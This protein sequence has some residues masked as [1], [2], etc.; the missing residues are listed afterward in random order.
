MN[1]KHIVVF[2]NHNPTYITTDPLPTSAI[3]GQVFW[4]SSTSSLMVWD[5][6]NWQPIQMQNYVEATLQ[7]ESAAAVDWAIEKMH[8]I[9][10]LRDLADKYPTVAEAL[11]QLEFAVK[12]HRNVDDV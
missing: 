12:M 5:G 1:D 9:D 4:S 3:P 11:K 2:N 10:T 7:P 6:Y 8:E